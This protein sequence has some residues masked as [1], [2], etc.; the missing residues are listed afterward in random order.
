MLTSLDFLEE[1]QPWPPKGE[2]D[3]L[4]LYEENYCLRE[5]DV[6]RVWPDLNKY[7][8]DDKPKEL[9]F[10]LGY[11]ALVTKKTCDL[12][13]GEPCKALLPKTNRKDNPKQP[14]L[15]D[16][17]TSLRYRQV[18]WEQATDIDSLGDAVQKVYRDAHGNVK[19]ATINPKHWFPIIKEGTY[20]V[21]Y[22]VLAFIRERIENDEEKHYL[23]VEIHSPSFIEH[24]IYELNKSEILGGKR[25]DWAGWSP[26]IK[27]IEPNEAG[28]F[29]VIIA[30]NQKSGGSCYGKSSYGRDF[31]DVLR[32]L[33]IRYATPNHVLDVFGKPTITGP[34]EYQDYDPVTKKMVFRP[35]Q[36]LGIN[37]DPHTVAVYPQALVWD[38]HLTEGRNE[39]ED[40]RNELFNISEMSPILF[41]ANALAGA[42]ESGTAIRLR[43]I[44][45]LAKTARIREVI[46][47]AATKA[48]RVV[49]LLLGVDFD[50]VYFEWKDGLPEVEQ[51]KAAYYTLMLPILGRKEILR[52]E[53]YNDEEITEIMADTS[54]DQMPDSN[55]AF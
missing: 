11:P 14:I 43:L 17:Y 16:V 9:D 54:A 29:L 26:G 22:H 21:E 13:M 55:L 51:E 5:N 44:N 10:W 7:L 53:G 33:I 52:L 34:K 50:L 32:K 40:L 3:R 12:I 46:D 35:G 30:S 49:G 28:E 39:R 37:P 24:R 45:T 27:E 41:S 18:L 42:A 23:E 47:S 25:L 19:V 2:E 20:E 36:Y 6:N 31:K 38:A 8:R 4:A 15:D 1:K 48:L